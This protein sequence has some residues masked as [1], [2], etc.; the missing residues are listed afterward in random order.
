[1]G[2][3]PKE[4]EQGACFPSDWCS[5]KQEGGDFEAKC[6]VFKKETSLAASAGGQEVTTRE[7]GL[8]GA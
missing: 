6:S 7:R 4:V 1:M 5:G 3:I 8:D 2:G